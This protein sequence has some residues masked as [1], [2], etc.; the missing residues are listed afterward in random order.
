MGCVHCG[1][2]LNE[3]GLLGSP[4]IYDLDAR[5]PNGWAPVEPNTSNGRGVFGRRQCMTSVWRIEQGQTGNRGG[6]GAAG[7]VCACTRLQAWGG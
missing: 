7:H 1:E 5:L 6:E 4:R 2:T 3:P